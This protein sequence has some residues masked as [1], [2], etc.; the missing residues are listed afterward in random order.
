[1]DIS[2]IKPHRATC[3]ICQADLSS[4]ECSSEAAKWLVM[5]DTDSSLIS[6]QKI[7][8]RCSEV[9][10]E[11]HMTVFGI[12]FV[13]MNDESDIDISMRELRALIEEYDDDC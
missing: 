3:G 4:E 9:I 1:M 10:S 2:I 11:A 13:D 7:C 8:K 12:T 5:S 6:A